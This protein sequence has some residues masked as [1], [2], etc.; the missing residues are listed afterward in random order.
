MSIQIKY[1]GVRGSTPV[2]GKDFNHFGGNTT[3]V[4]L[5]ID[6]EHIIFDG[7]TG[8]RP[9]GLD[10]LATFGKAGGHAHIFFTHTHWDHI[11]GIPF[12]IPIY[13]P[14]NRFDIY[15]ET[16][17]IPTPG[18]KEEKR[19]TIED[20]LAMQQNF[21]YFPVSTRDL[22]SAMNF[23]EINEK[24]TIELHKG[25]I[26]ITTIN[27]RHPNT[28]L[29]FRVDFEGKSYVFCTDVEHTDECT[30]RIGEF[31]KGADILAYDCQ[32]TPEEY[33]ASKI[34]WGHSTYAIAAD[35]ARIGGI[36]KVHM[37]H[38]DPM[39]TD[40]ALFD[41]EKKAQALNPNMIMVNE[42]LSVEI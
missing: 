26:R 36:K 1:Y 24:Q 5:H 41:L 21:M 7:G 31:A 39:H 27:L 29:G 6:G 20:V 2:S 33:Q 12:F 14:Q 32:Y 30:H 42:G 22:A 11:Q 19:W 16:K 34:G 38:H 4:Y 3:C 17:M 13:M 9:L 35:I 18:S 25:K 40:K 10:L 15:G 37:V 8:I 28:S 23:H